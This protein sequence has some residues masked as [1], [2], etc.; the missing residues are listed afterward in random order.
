MAVLRRS[1]CRSRVT[2]LALIILTF[3]G[4]TGSWHVDSDDPDCAVPVAHNHSSHHER[5]GSNGR[6]SAAGS[7]RDLSLASELPHRWCPP[8]A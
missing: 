5:R 4:T 1:I 2:A 3:L 8:G 6:G 7:L